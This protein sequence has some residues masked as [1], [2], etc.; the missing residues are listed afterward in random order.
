MLKKTTTLLI[1]LGG[2]ILV[3]TLAQA[4]CSACDVAKDY[5]I[6]GNTEATSGI[7]LDEGCVTGPG[8]LEYSASI[9]L[10]MALDDGEDAEALLG[11]AYLTCDSS[12]AQD[13]LDAAIAARN[14]A[15]NVCQSYKCREKCPDNPICPY[16]CDAYDE[17]R[18]GVS[19]A[20]D[21]VDQTQCPGTEAKWQS[22]YY[23]Q[24]PYL[25]PGQPSPPVCLSSDRCLYSTGSS[26]AR[27]TIISDHWLCS[28]ER[29]GGHSQGVW[30]LCESTREAAGVTMEGR[31]CVLSGSTYLWQ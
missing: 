26:A 15:Y 10:G 31:Q 23:D 13:G 2:L 18:D 21:C 8:G 16:A 1:V 11:D 19:S 7:P 3:P 29:I 25:S 9:V 30:Y 28:A 6:A 5:V 12:D 17:Y 20:V 24:D 4:V 14:H 27:G 22:N